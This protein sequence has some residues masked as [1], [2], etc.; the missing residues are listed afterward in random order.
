MLHPKYNMRPSHGIR[1]EAATK[2]QIFQ[3]VDCCEGLLRRSGTEIY[4]AS[5]LKRFERL[6]IGGPA[7]S[8]QMED[9]EWTGPESMDVD[10]PA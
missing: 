2:V 3:K 10:V 7:S 8:G 4:P 9:I 6:S 5:M 1:L